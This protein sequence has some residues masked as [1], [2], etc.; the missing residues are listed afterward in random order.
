MSLSDEERIVGMTWAVKAIVEK[1]RNFLSQVHKSYD[2]Y[3]CEKIFELI[4]DLWHGLLGKNTNGL[5]WITGS[6]ATN[7][8]TWDTNTP[9]GTA[10]NHHC[11]GLLKEEKDFWK[12]HEDRKLFDAF[13]GFLNIE[14]LLSQTDRKC[15]FVYSVYL[16]T[17]Q[18]SYYLRRYKD[19]LL[20][21]FENLD[22]LVSD[23]QGECFNF[24]STN[25]VFA[26]AYILNAL[27][28]N[29]LFGP[30]YPYQK[31]GEDV[32]LDWFIAHNV[33]HDV[34]L[35]MHECDEDSLKWLARKHREF[36]KKKDKVTA[37]DRIL[38]M[39]ELSGR[40]FE[41]QHEFDSLMKLVKE[42]KICSPKEIKKLE[43]VFK[44]CLEAKKKNDEQN[45]EKYAPKSPLSIYD[46]M[47]E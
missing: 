24:F 46:I 23:I 28:K 13:E 3:Q 36:H 20:K 14:G 9:W 17:E 39:M 43:K 26:R 5:H 10:I 32:V 29:Y 11:C 21:S 4:D 22:K 44:N 40:R 34:S 41:Y 33:H 16:W 18:L 12:E 30:K 38:L 19:D 7:T 47:E 25:P 35:L 2:T 8:I 45:H 15:A 27:C 31:E 6:S 37:F 1:K 42:K